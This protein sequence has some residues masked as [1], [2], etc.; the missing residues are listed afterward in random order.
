M[1]AIWKG[2]LSFGLVNIPIHMYTASREKEISFVMLH[3]KDHSEIR[4]VR[5]CKTENK[6]V[7][8]KEIVKAYEFEKGNFVILQDEDF[9]KV[10]LKKT[11]TIEIIQFIEEDEIDT[12]YYVKPYFLEPDK[13]AENAYKL[14]REALRKSKKVGLAKYVIRN[15]EHIAVVKVHENMLILNELRY[16]NELI[17]AEDLKIPP[18][19]KLIGKEIDIAIQLINHLTA[20]FTPQ[21]YKDTYSEEL[22]Q[23]IKKKA[24]G[25]PIHPK[26]EEE[27]SSKVHDI[28]S[29]LQASL[30]NKK[31]PSKKKT[32]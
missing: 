2:A 32:A 16:Q 20:P 30:E 8:W 12:M 31:K 3:K 14:L 21:K 7:P 26:T 22:K 18:Q 13:N 5:M 29:L 11:K 19:S 4:Y 6:E 9:E 1:H 24:K 23:M 28:M 27:S 15:R 25:R 10:N 17:G